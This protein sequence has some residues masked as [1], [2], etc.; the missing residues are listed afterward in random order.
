[1]EKW[2]LG[3]SGPSVIGPLADS[4]STGNSV[5]FC[6]GNLYLCFLLLLICTAGFCKM[7][8]AKMKKKLFSPILLHAVWRYYLNFPQ[9]NIYWIGTTVEPPYV[10][11]KLYF[12]TGFRQS[13]DWRID[14]A[15]RLQLPKENDSKTLNAVVC[16]LEAGK[17]TI[18]PVCPAWIFVLSKNVIV[19]TS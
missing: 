4:R 17:H 7:E 15:H 6:S 14:T 16:L 3:R 2:Q 19:N 10:L 12:M 9:V 1:M 11:T 13:T 18:D 5:Q 8:K